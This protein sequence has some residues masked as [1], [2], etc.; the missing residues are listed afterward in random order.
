[1]SEE[2][3][4]AVRIDDEEEEV[5]DTRVATRKKTSAAK[6]KKKKKRHINF[7]LIIALIICIIPCAVVG[8]ILYEAMQDTNSVI[9]G[10]RFAN[11][12]DPAITEDMRSSILT[13]VK[14]I[15]GVENAELSLTTATL[16][17]M[18][19]MNDTLT[20]EDANTI[21]QA[22]VDVVDQNAPLKTYFTTNGV[23]K[24]YDLEIIIY[25]ML[26][27]DVTTSVYVI[28]S[29]NGASENVTH[30]SL[31]T[32]KNPEKVA[33]IEAARYAEEHPEEATESDT[34]SDADTA[35]KAE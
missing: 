19:D 28:Y 29:K 31:S 15:D 34:A 13:G 32:A 14:M 25:D 24:M 27:D 18:I 6:K 35:T 23:K 5:T 2:Y 20:E 26:G 1:M 11:D 17:I 12:L 3:T 16:R 7:F 9:N 22:A 30:Q 8:Y 4:K 10:E 21:G 33:E